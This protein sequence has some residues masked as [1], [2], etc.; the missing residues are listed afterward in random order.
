MDKP[1]LQ[2]LDPELAK[3]L[4]LA[5]T[6]SNEELF[7][8]VTDLSPEVIRAAL[9]NPHLNEDHLLALLNRVDLV[10]DILKA[11]Y[12]H[13]QQNQSRQLKKALVRNPNTPGP[14]T[15]ALLPHLYLF[16]L[17]DLCFMPG[18][19][20]DQKI[21]AERTIIQRLPE[22]ELGN[23]ITLSRRATANVVGAILKEGDKRLT[24]ACLNN[25]RLKEVSILQFLNSAKAKPD[26][27]SVI[28][29][30]SK[31]KNRPNLRMAMLKNRNTP[32]VWFTLF[33]PQLKTTDLNNLLHSKRLNNSQKKLVQGEL[34][35]RGG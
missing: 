12:Q 15:L 29:R 20:P 14:I 32:N 2:K 1:E 5:L 6:A 18:V 19:T 16:E 33:L 9:K 25:P 34:R 26:T 10:E 22:I 35:K 24:A 8:V 31:W 4:H 23:K 7:Q 17:V 30:H 21:A 3:R 28:A 11:V 27:I 13:E